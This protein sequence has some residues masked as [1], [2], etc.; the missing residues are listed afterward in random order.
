MKYQPEEAR[1]MLCVALGEV[2]Q[3]QDRLHLIDCQISQDCQKTDKTDAPLKTIK[4]CVLLPHINWP[5]IKICEDSG[6]LG[7]LALHHDLLKAL[8]VLDYLDESGQ[9]GRRM[10]LG[11]YLAARNHAAAID[12][13][14]KIMGEL[15]SSTRNVLDERN[16]VS[17]FYIRPAIRVKLEIDNGAICRA[18]LSSSLESRLVYIEPLEFPATSSIVENLDEVREVTL[19]HLAQIRP[20]AIRYLRR[21]GI[22]WLRQKE[23]TM[24]SNRH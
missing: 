10:R 21:E 17:S 24:R 13:S 16:S 3:L 18:A 22:D 19:V 2:C 9:T 11:A 6:V 14:R 23:E 4:A 12:Y 20:F 1:I 7:F 15:P 5:P 8:S